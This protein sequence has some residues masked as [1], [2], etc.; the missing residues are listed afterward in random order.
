MAAPTDGLWHHVTY[1]YD[2]TTDRLYL[3][4]AVTSATGVAHQTAA[5][6]AVY[7]GSYNGAAEILNGTID[8]VRIYNAALTDTQVARLAAGRYAGTGGLVTMTLGAATTVAS[9]FAIDSANL[10]SSTFTFNHSL[11]SAAAAINSGSYTS[12]ARPSSSRAASPSSRA[13]R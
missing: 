12:A 7:I 1:T 10:S 3:D 11:T 13:G 8:D 9:T 2:G 4:G 5:T 6:T